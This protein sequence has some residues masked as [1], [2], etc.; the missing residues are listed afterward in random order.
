MAL[1]KSALDHLEAAIPEKATGGS[2]TPLMR[3]VRRRKK[4]EEDETEEEESESG[5]RISDGG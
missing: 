3:I 4:N 2:N 5:N 1:L